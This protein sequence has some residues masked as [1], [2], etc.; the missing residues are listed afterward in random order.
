MFEAVDIN[1]WFVCLNTYAFPVAFLWA[2]Q[3]MFSHLQSRPSYVYRLPFPVCCIF[4]TV[5]F[6]AGFNYTLRM[7]AVSGP[8]FTDDPNTNI[9]EIED[10]PLNKGTAALVPIYTDQFDN[11]PNIDGLEIRDLVKHHEEE[12][13]EEYLENIDQNVITPFQWSDSPFAKVKHESLPDK[14]AFDG[15]N[16]KWSW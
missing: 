5:L 11:V 10:I 13:I 14:W 3:L 9:T 8:P 4:L 6:F 15:L 2:L 1:C 16:W 12:A 7:T